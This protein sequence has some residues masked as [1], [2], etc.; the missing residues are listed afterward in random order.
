MYQST[1]YYSLENPT[2]L[3]SVDSFGHDFVQN[4][5]LPPTIQ[6]CHYSFEPLGLE[7][8]L[9]FNSQACFP[10]PPDTPQQIATTSPLLQLN[11]LEPTEWEDPKFFNTFRD[12]TVQKSRSV[13][14]GT[15]ITVG[16]FGQ[17][18]V[19]SLQ[20]ENYRNHRNQISTK[21]IHKCPEP[22]CNQSFQRS[23]N[24]KSHSRCHL[25]S[26]PHKCHQCGLGFKRTNDLH[27]HFR[28]M[29]T[30]ESEMPL[31]CDKCNR[32]FGRSDALRRHQTSKSRDLG[33][34]GRIIN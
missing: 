24:L 27:R 17:V 26:T 16:N 15:Q 29:H 20:V 3:Q 12:S 10:S 23:Q 18:P 33:C 13:S 5:N 25:T 4:D 21:G 7:F 28:T 30:A 6:E 31:G 2:I 1:Q 9:N 19:A 22:G 11:S 32:R 34:P 8:G 14:L